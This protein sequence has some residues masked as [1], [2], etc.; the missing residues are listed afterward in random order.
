M[1]IAQ[2]RLVISDPAGDK[3]VLIRLYQP[4]GQDGAWSCRYEIDWPGRARSSYAG[5]ADSMQA[6]MLALQ[7]IGIEIYTSSYHESGSLKWTE[8]NRGYG[9]PVGFNVRDLLIGDDL[10]L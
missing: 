1:V 7:K 10:R 2:R 8:P 3:D 6:L 9:F 5:G 4:E